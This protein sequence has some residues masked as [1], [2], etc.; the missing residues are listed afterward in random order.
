MCWSL[1]SR[2]WEQRGPFREQSP[3]ARA[4]APARDPSQRVSHR[5]YSQRLTEIPPAAP[6]P[7]LGPGLG[8]SRGEGL[9][10]RP[11][12]G[13]QA[14]PS[15]DSTLKAPWPGANSPPRP[16]SRAVRARRGRRPVLAG[17]GAR[18]S[19]ARRGR[20]HPRS[21]PGSRVLRGLLAAGGVGAEPGERM[22]QPS[23]RGR[24]GGRRA[25]R[26]SPQPGDGVGW[27]QRGGESWE[28]R[29]G[30]RGRTHL[31]LGP[32]LARLALQAQGSSV[33]RWWRPGVTP[34]SPGRPH[35]AR[36]PSRLSPLGG[37]PPPGR[38]VNGD[39]ETAVLELRL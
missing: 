9:A 5:R 21:G 22:L 15:L 1:A 24:G 26:W 12:S 33:T 27:G 32:R 20:P 7:P 8:T 36:S 23:P 13:T 37:R 6:T 29:R 34:C 19:P 31:A 35:A 10:E 14:A 38:P 3:A 4:A 11:A 17:P 16:A 30:R 18:G 28:R 25:T 39:H 2:P